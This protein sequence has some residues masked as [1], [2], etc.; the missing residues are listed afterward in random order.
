MG[1]YDWFVQGYIDALGSGN[2]QNSKIYLTRSLGNHEGQFFSITGICHGI[3][4]VSMNRPLL[5]PSS[6]SRIQIFG[7]DEFMLMSIDLGPCHP[8]S[9]WALTDRLDS[10][11]KRQ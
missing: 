5:L 9:E 8:Q 7:V 1:L 2:S 4:Q 10:I 11:E 6:K 3:S